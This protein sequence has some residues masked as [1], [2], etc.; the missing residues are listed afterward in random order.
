MCSYTLETI[1]CVFR[2][3]T[4]PIEAD[5]EEY[6]MDQE[7]RGRVIIFNHEK[8]KEGLGV[9]ERTGTN[10]DKIRLKQRFEKLKFDVEVFDDLKVDE[11]RN[12]LTESKY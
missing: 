11:I 5:A 12:K 1:N 6:K 2:Q 10:N 8:F 3:Y 7:K 9:E 4:A